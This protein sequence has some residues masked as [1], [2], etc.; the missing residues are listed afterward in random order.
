MKKYKEDIFCFLVFGIVIFCTLLTKNLNNLDEIWIFNMARN[1]TNGLLPYKDFNMIT[2]PGLPILCG[3]ILKLFG[4][5]LLVMRILAV[6]LNTTILFGIYKILKLF[7]INKY[8]L[9]FIMLTITGVL[10]EIFAIDYNL[11]IL[12]IS[13]ICLYIELKSYYTTKNILHYNKKQE[14][15]LG[16]L[17]GF[18]ILIKQT[19]GMCF[20]IGFIGYKLL[21]VKTK[22][23]FKQFLK[24]AITRLSAVIVP[25]IL[26]IVYLVYNNIVDEFIEYAI[27]GIK[28]FSNS[29]SYIYLLKEKVWYLAILVPII[30]IS[31]FIIFIKKNENVLLILWA[32]SM[33]MIIV[34]Y[35]IADTVHFLIGGII[36]II[37][38]IYILI[39]FYNNKIKNEINAQD[40]YN[41]TKLIKIFTRIVIIII[42]FS[43]VTKLLFYIKNCNYYNNLSNFKYIPVEKELEEQILEVDTYI[44]E[45]Q[46]EVY[47]LDATA[48]IYMIPLHRYNKNYDMF[49]IGNL[50]EKGSQVII[51][52]LKKKK[53]A[54]ILIQKEEKLMNW[55]TPK[56][57][58]EYIKDNYVK[59]GEVEIFDIYRK[60]K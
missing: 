2:T 57:V 17:V 31:S 40:I 33:F 25:V 51:D 24:I 19:T 11:F 8:W 60:E 55:Q 35:P 46:E 59:D 52:D 10:I 21:A 47:I 28:E 22:E 41:A 14:V 6:I 26:L 43:S 54:N 50:G 49:L 53:N 3:A 29:I 45:K 16:F 4:T 7:N 18:S 23:D 42:I 34:I 9:R 32:Y 12:L 30:I 38:G 15:L 48:A 13:L 58:I 36:A 39:K 37:T 1:V 27:L 20:A 56:E 5:E 44:K